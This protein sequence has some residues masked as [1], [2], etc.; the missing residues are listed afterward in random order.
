MSKCVLL[1]SIAPIDVMTGLGGKNVTIP[2]IS[3]NPEDFRLLVLA[4]YPKLQ[5]GG[6][7]ELLRCKPQSR[8]LLLI[9][10]RI[11]GSPKLLKQHVGDGKCTLDP[12]SEI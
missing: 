1:T 5:N 8:E 12:H 10:H 9:G 2:N 11:S 6:G 7:F 4:T 3:C